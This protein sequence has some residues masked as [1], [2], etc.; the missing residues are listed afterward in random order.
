MPATK[1][2]TFDVPGAVITYDVHEPAEPSAARPL[3]VV[4]SPMGAAGF[5]TL[6]SHFP[7]RTVVTYDPPGMER[8]TVT[9]T[10][11]YPDPMTRSAALH[12]IAEAV[13][14]GPYDF[15]GSSGGA[16]DGL[17]WVQ[18]FPDD[19]ALAVLHEPPLPAVLPDR[20]VLV[21]AMDDILHTYEAH[22]FGAGM[23]KFLALV[24]AQGEL[25]A[26]YLD[27]PAP[28]PGQFGLPAEDDGKR[29]DPLLDINMRTIPRWEPAFDAVRAAATRIV[30][31]YGEDSA[32]TMAARGARGLAEELDVA[33]AVMPGDH[34]AFMAGEYGQVGKPDEFAASLRALL[35]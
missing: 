14:L 2:V 21:A 1:T 20:D 10:G 29:G 15:F 34:G 19:L 28:D 27:Q 30:P 25:P 7:D 33:P 16:V 12:T 13:G 17:A 26:D 8:S 6:V 22:G 35:T 11:P 18:Q 32:E 24:M 5:T 31:A 3:F 9:G 4:G 23:A